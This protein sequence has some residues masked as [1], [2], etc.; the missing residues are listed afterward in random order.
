MRQSGFAI[1]TITKGL[2]VTAF[3]VAGSASAQVDFTGV[4]SPRLQDE[5]GPERGPGP[6]LVEFV[7][8]PINDYARQWSLAYTSEADV[9]ADC[10]ESTDKW[11]RIGAMLSQHAR[12]IIA[13]PFQPFAGASSISRSYSSPPIWGG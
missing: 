11:I 5:D 13:S 2:F 1:R 9:L 8:L 3:L 6:S 4:W 10:A 7:G 12:R